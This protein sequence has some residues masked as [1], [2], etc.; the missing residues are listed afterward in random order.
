MRGRWVCDRVKKSPR[1]M[2]SAQVRAGGRADDPAE[3]AGCGRP[4]ATRRIRIRTIG[5]HIHTR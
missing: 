2:P 3:E 1:A 4:L 5:C